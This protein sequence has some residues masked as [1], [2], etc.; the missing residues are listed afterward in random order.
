LLPP[1]YQRKLLTLLPACDRILSPVDGYTLSYVNIFFFIL[2]QA[3]EVMLFIS[4]ISIILIV[5]KQ[6]FLL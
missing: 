6:V 3:G 1:A 4:Y 2:T 5:S